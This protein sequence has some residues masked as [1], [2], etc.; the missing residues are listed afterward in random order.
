MHMLI[1]VHHLEAIELI[2]YLL[3]LLCLAL[4]NRLD[5]RCIPLDICTR[6]FLVL[7][8]RFHSAAGYFSIVD[9][10]NPVI[11][12]GARL[13]LCSVHVGVCLDFDSMYSQCKGSEAD[14]PY[15]GYYSR[16][17][18]YPAAASSF[19]LT[20]TVCLI[21]MLFMSSR[22]DGLDKLRGS[23]SMIPIH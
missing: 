1:E 13:N 17:Y 23:A 9:V 12:H 3:D 7:T 4:R 2:R 15:L 10:L 8:S 5:T 19:H 20:D 16:L 11:A 21:S 14:L 6:C 18:V 22:L